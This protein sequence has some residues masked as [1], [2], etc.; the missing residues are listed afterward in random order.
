MLR[1]ISAF[2]LLTLLLSA[3]GCAV[4]P[5]CGGDCSL[6][7]CSISETRAR[8]PIEQLRYGITGGGCGELY[9]GEPL[10]SCDS[11]NIRPGSAAGLAGLLGVRHHEHG[12]CS[13]CGG[14]DGGCASCNSHSSHSTHGTV[15]HDEVIEHSIHSPRSMPRSTSPVTPPSVTPQRQLPGPESGA[16]RSIM[17]NRT[18]TRP[19]TA[20]PAPRTQR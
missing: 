14:H 13:E 1:A 17:R 6:N 10:Y 5:R 2:S 20:V 8:N 12:S 15:I 11:C 7:D 4:A 3:S 9:W 19:T 16:S 18:T